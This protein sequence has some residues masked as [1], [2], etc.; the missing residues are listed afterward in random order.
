MDCLFCNIVKGRIPSEIVYDDPHILA[1]KD[2]NP[3]APTHVLVIP[4]IHID[5]ITS[6]KPEHQE[7]MGHLMCSI[8]RIVKDLGLTGRGVRIVNNCE[9]EAGQSVFHVHFHILGGRSFAWPPG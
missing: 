5:R 2:I 9:A 1:F 3:I 7:I 4:K 6:L 8:P